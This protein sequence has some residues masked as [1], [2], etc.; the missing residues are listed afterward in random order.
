M[1]C[2]K[3][4]YAEPDP[5]RCGACG[6]YF[7]KFRQQPQT[8]GRRRDRLA[9]HRSAGGF[10]WGAIALTAIASAAFSGHFARGT[11]APRATVPPAGVVA[12]SGEAADPSGVPAGERAP[13]ELHGLAA[14]LARTA[15]ARNEIESARN[16]TVLI[17]TRFGYG[18]GFI[19]DAACHVI[20]SRHVLDNESAREGA[21]AVAPADLRTSMPSVDEQRLRA[22]IEQ[23]RQLRETLVGQPGTNLQLLELDGRIQAMQQQLSAL[24][25]HG[26]AEPAPPARQAQTNE[27]DG[28]SVT[29]VDGTRF[30]GL[31]AQFSY[32]VDLAMFQ[33][34]AVDCPHLTP[35]QSTRLAQGERLYTIGNPSGLA[36]SVTSGIFSGDRGSGDQRFLQTDAP[37]NPGNSG[38]PLVT[39]AGRVVGINTKVLSGVQGIGFAIPIEAAYREFGALR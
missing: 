28:F 17:E 25:A 14:Q 26:E 19:I 31:Q 36:Y 2:P 20:T 4:G 32:H 12:A 1:S 21:P 5:V 38:G 10:G 30:N 37:I 11:S 18:S 27:P 9:G 24:S 7:E 29:L 34:P 15:P 8:R 33:L 35:A 6:I 23:Q 22:Q 16:A 13:E 3:C 39:A